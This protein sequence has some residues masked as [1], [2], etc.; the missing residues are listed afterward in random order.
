[1]AVTRSWTAPGAR[2]AV[3]AISAARPNRLEWVWLVAASLF[4]AG[5]LAMV[6]GAKAQDFA[7]VDRRLA[8]G[9]LVNLNPVQS[10]QELVPIQR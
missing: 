3:I 10:P 9:D 2:P 6:F 1:M 5:A 7:D 8:H 4:V